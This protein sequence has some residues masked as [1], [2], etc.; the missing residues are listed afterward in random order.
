[1][2]YIKN[3]VQKAKNKFKR[4]NSYPGCVP[5][6]K[7]QIEENNDLME[8]KICLATQCDKC[9][10]MVFQTMKKCKNCNKTNICI[11]CF[12]NDETLCEDCDKDLIYLYD[13]FDDDL[14]KN[15]K[16]ED[17]VDQLL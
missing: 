11:Y 12:K 2:N 9:K 10:E 16:I 7:K 15:I 4:S 5:D 3:Q 14:V 13:C 1:M 6:N 17:F 8:V